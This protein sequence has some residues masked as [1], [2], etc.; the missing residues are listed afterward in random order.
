MNTSNIDARAFYLD[1]VN[2]F[3]T[4]SGISNHYDI[5]VDQAGEL[6]E[7]GRKLHEAFVKSFLSA[8]SLA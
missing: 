1:W 8:D 5:S 4:I 7:N 3:L 2:N 6:V